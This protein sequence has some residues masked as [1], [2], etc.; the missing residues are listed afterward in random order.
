VL[1]EEEVSRKRSICRWYM[2]REDLHTVGMR[3]L[4]VHSLTEATLPITSPLSP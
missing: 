1:D 2:E 4:L 3:M